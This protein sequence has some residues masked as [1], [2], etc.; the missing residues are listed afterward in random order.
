MMKQI[1]VVLP[2]YLWIL[3][4]GLVV[5]GIGSAIFRIVP[6]LP[7]QMPL[8]VRGAFGIDFWH[9]W[10]HIL[11]GVAGLA[12]LAISRTREPLIRLAVIFGVFY[13]LLEVWGVLAHHPLNL[14][15]DLPEHVFHLTAGP[16][17]LLVGLR[18]PVGKAA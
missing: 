12:V 15:L 13:T 10:I 16:L 17:S 18:A 1:A 7:A 6:S 11:W 5:Q 3:M 2:I 4:G 14:E 9:A 8:L